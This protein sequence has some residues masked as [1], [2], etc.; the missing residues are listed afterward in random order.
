MFHRP[1]RSKRL[2]LALL[3]MGMSLGM[4]VNVA[5]P[6]QAAPFCNGGFELPVIGVPFQQFNAPST[7][8][9]CWNVTVNNVDIV[10]L[11]T[12]DGAQ[13]LDLNGVSQG[14]ICQTF[15]TA[16]GAPYQVGFLMAGA[17]LASPGTLTASITGGPTFNATHPGGGT[18][19]N[20]NLQF[21]SFNFN[22]G[23]GTT[24]TLCFASTSG[25]AGGPVIDAV[26]VTALLPVSLIDA[27]VAGAVGVALAAAAAAVYL[28]RRQQVGGQTT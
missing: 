5:G 9:N 2:S 3:T 24:S 1:T 27:R 26:T 17:G 25:G 6:A 7:A 13:G 15:D 11:N 21:R 4:L 16:A 28:R 12:P 22:A 23:A 19:A 10:Q 14:T 20:P 8:I 18:G